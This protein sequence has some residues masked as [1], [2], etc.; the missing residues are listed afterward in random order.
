M[1][2]IQLLDLGLAFLFF[3]MINIYHYPHNGPLLRPEPHIDHTLL[4]ENK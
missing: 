2:Y 3:L 4:K 1:Q